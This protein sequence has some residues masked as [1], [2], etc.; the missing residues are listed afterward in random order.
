M[1]EAEI[2]LLLT[3][4]IRNVAALARS[5]AGASRQA[6]HAREDLIQTG[7]LELV[8]LAPK[9]SASRG[10][11]FWSFA[12]LRVRGAMIDYLR[13]AGGDNRIAYRH[14]K[15]TVA[16]SQFACRDDQSPILSRLVARDFPAVAEQSLP[17]DLL[18]GLSDED[19]YILTEKFVHG[20]TQ[21][22][23]GKSLGLCEA[24][25][26]LRSTRAIQRI[27]ERELAAR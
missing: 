15:R 4:N 13:S 26:S 10:V 25:I 23:I 12:A 19:R 14:G 22:D 16:M 17:D 9:F 7:L 24:A 8:K 5:V 27:R 3:E 21:K 6:R 11:K 2:D 20:R 1:T 18:R